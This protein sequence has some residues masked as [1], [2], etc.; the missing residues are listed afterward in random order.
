ML[1]N[2]TICFAFMNYEINILLIGHLRELKIVHFL[3]QKINYYCI[4]KSTL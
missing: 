1:L 3:L 4:K 2:L